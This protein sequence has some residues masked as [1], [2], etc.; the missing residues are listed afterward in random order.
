MNYIVVNWV[1]NHKDELFS[2]NDHE[3]KK[4]KTSYFK[5]FITLLPVLGFLLNSVSTLNIL[6]KKFFVYN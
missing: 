3:P 1:T 6:K 2:V 4:K 5:N